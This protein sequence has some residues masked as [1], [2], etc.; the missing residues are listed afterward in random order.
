MSLKQKI[1]DHAVIIFGGALIAGFIAGIVAFDRAVYMTSK[2]ILPADLPANIKNLSAELDNLKKEKAAV[3]ARLIKSQE[4]LSTIKT[5]SQ[6][7]AAATNASATPT[8]L[9]ASSNQ[10][11]DNIEKISPVAQVP[12]SQQTQRIGEIEISLRKI[13][14]SAEGLT[15]HFRLINRG[16]DDQSLALFGKESYFGMSQGVT[17]LFANGKV[18]NATNIMIGNK[19]D[20]N[21]L[22]IN[23]IPGI[24]IDGHISFGRIP[25]DIQSIDLLTFTYFLGNKQTKG[26]ARFPKV[27]LP[28]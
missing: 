11:I 25:T 9:S 28:I 4:E 2:A 6:P 20:N 21:L 27:A 7:A 18:I 22:N 13:E 8:N 14:R 19:E 15:V 26:S 23:F 3:D 17:Q 1:E 16:N 12:L 24:P 5:H 10:N